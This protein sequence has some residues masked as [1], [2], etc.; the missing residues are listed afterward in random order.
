MAYFFLK[1]FDS[2]KKSYIYQQMHH[3]QYD[4]NKLIRDIAP[5]PTNERLT[6]SKKRLNKYGKH[7]HTGGC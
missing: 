6:E 1:K 3:S 4:A 7:L 2:R 5:H